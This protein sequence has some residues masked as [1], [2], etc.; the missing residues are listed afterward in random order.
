MFAHCKFLFWNARNI[1]TGPA[2]YQSLTQSMEL[3][4]A[5]F[6]FK[7]SFFIPTCHSVL[8]DRGLT[9]IFKFSHGEFLFNDSIFTLR[10]QIFLLVLSVVSKVS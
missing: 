4:E 5:S 2:V 6:D 10:L 1:T 9:N 7:I 8:H 3:I